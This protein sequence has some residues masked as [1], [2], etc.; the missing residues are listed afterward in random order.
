MNYM[1]GRDD[2][3]SSVAVGLYNRTQGEYK[4]YAHGI[5]WPG[6][7]MNVPADYVSTTQ[8]DSTNVLPV[9]AGALVGILLVFLLLSLVYYAAKD[10]ERTK[11]VHDD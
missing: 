4:A 10:P 9:V 2:V 5:V 8:H 11:K 6:G 3:M 7:T 1:V